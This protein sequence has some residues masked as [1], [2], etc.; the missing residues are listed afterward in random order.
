VTA[1]EE[2][3]RPEKARYAGSA[4]P[5]EKTRFTGSST[6]PSN[7]RASSS[8]APTVNTAAAVASESDQAGQNDVILSPTVPDAPP[9][10]YQ[11]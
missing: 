9:P 10:A 7:A 2:S 11:L 8:A 6:S 5:P 1:A 4:A 3:R